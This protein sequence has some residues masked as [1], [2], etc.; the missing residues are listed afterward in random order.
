MRHIVSPAVVFCVVLLA[1]A[2]I[3][4]A[5]VPTL[6]QY[7]GFLTDDSGEPFDTWWI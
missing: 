7:Q 5:D 3:A 6:M 2:S 4:T 1:V